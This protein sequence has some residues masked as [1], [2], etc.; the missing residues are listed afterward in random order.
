MTWL[1]RLLPSSPSLNRLADRKYR[2]RAPRGRNRTVN[3]EHLEHRTLLAGNV[4]VA[5]V[6]P[7]GTLVVLL[8][9]H[10]DHV[11]INENGGNTV[12]VSGN[13]STSVNHLPLGV[14]V[15]RFAV[16]NIL[17]EV[18]GTGQNSPVINL[19][20][21]A[22]TSSG[23]KAVE[24]G[25]GSVSL[26]NGPDVTFNVTNVHNGGPLLVIDTGGQLHATVTGS[27]FTAI[28]ISQVGCCPATVDL[29]N[30]RVNGS[31]EV[32]EGV[33]N[34]D[35]ITL[36]N[37]VFGATLLEQGQ[38]PPVEGCTGKGDHISVNDSSL[39]ELLALQEGPGGGQTI[40]V[41]TTSDVQVNVF[42]FGVIA[43][44][45]GNGD[46]DTILIVSITTL[47]RFPIN[48][49]PGPEQDNII[50]AQ[51]NGAGDTA[52]V[53]SSMV[54]GNITILQGNGAKDFAGLF[55]DTAPGLT[56]TIGPFVGEISGGVETIVQGDGDNDIAQ[57]DCG[58]IENVGAI[59]T[60][61]DLFVSQGAALF[62]PGCNQQVGDTIIVNCSNI[63]SDMT[64][65]Q[66][67]G[68]NS[69]ADLGANLIEVAA[70]PGAMPVFVG[71]FSIIDELGAN[72]GDNTILIG[73]A[74]GGPDSGSIDFETGT[75]DV[76]AGNGG[77]SYVQ[78]ENSQADFIPSFLGIF[79][80]FNINAGGDGN[81][82]FI[83]VF[84]SAT[85]DS[86]F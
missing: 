4:T 20:Q 18:A 28:I 11:T 1:S 35:T 49:L 24:L 57:V 53:D 3:L 16:L 39:G 58:Q 46:G 9:T 51:G 13:G 19:T 30:D 74:S 63:T 37:D 47:A 2:P 7:F 45:T 72:N 81:T 10:S 77:G 60:A 66:G 50:V 29:N 65:E 76:F 41:G 73:G 12:T 22:G 40:E 64:L 26:T 15:T 27:S 78:V 43:E 70:T 59:N 61:L 34:G 83:D 38:G 6:D 86:A 25:I 32:S 54:F 67:E 80:P 5:P 17:I 31:V 69:D 75:L 48:K 55:G 85:I 71:G 68:P 36:E 84:S 8:D 14:S 62:T 82:S 52:I 79:G 21:T 56:I 23:I 33:A 42:G 44:Q